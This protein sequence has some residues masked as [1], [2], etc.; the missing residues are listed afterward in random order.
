MYGIDTANAAGLNSLVHEEEFS[1]EV[2]EYYE[3]SPQEDGPVSAEENSPLK[4]YTMFTKLP[5]DWVLFA[6]NTFSSTSLPTI[7]G[8]VGLTGALYIVDNST[9][10][11]MS[12]YARRSPQLRTWN[13]DFVDAGDGRY[14][15]GFIGTYAVYGFI[16][17]DS[18]ALRT[19]S[20]M[21][22]AIL[23]T[24]AVVQALKHISGRESPIAATSQRGAVR[25]FPSLFAYQHNQPK[26]YSFPSGHIATA[27]A[28]LTVL[29]ENFPEETWLRPISYVAL[30][31]V[32]E[33]LVSKGM[34]WYS[35]LPLGVALGY[36]FG[37]IAAS[38]NSS[39]LY[40]GRPDDRKAVELSLEPAINAGGGGIDFAVRF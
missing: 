37:S 39:E 32:G 20:Q 8:I 11:D 18:R 23:A 17:G 33:S 38:S 22:E 13:S 27:A 34:H 6:K 21:T 10:H 29:N 25:P 3:H 26:Y 28:S 36:S 12:I 24:G 19:A 15:F 31:A 1:T 14:E 7:G 40:S 35:D 2:L 9:Y 4:W 16:L 5:S 30:G